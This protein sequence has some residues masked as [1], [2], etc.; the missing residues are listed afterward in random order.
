MQF[1]N[2]IRSPLKLFLSFSLP[3]FFVQESNGQDSLNNSFIIQVKIWDIAKKRVESNGVKING[4][5]FPLT[6]GEYKIN[7]H[8][9]ND[10]DSLY[11][12][13]CSNPPAIAY[14]YYCK[15]RKGQVYNLSYNVCGDYYMLEPLNNP[16]SDSKIKPTVKYRITNYLSSDS[17]IGY[18]RYTQKDVL[19]TN[20]MISREV[21]LE[22]F[23]EAANCT[24]G[25]VSIGIENKS[26]KKLIKSDMSS[27]YIYDKMV[28]ILFFPLHP[29]LEELICEY[30]FKTNNYSLKFTK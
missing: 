19:L 10:F 22:N 14:P 7:Y 15:F 3:L 1:K 24:G 11:I 30:D 5:E 17:I 16:A 6:D 26:K 4:K 8:E 29:K 21:V 20:D 18:D 23:S 12:F 27:Y 25:A 13:N 2:F 28:D 9:N